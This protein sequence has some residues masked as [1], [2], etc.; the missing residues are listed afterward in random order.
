[1]HS[2]RLA[3]VG[4]RGCQVRWLIVVVTE[5]VF[6]SISTVGVSFLSL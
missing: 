2:S 3:V 4:G 6:A 5:E 1:M